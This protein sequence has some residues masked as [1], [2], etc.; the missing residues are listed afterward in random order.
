MSKPRKPI[1]KGGMDALI[2]PDSILMRRG[3]VVAIV[4]PNEETAIA[5]CELLQAMD[6]SEVGTSVE[7]TNVGGGKGDKRNDT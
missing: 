3:N 7:I 1:P 6:Q 4:F 5:Y 2:P